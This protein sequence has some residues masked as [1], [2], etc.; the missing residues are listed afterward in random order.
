M[1]K[2]IFTPRLAEII[3]GTHLRN[4]VLPVWLVES[5]IEI[6][7]MFNPDINEANLI[8]VSTNLDYLSEIIWGQDVEVATGVKSL[9]NSSFVL[10]HN[11]YQNGR[12]CARGQVTFI[13]YDYAAGV[14]KSIPQK[15]RLK[16]EEHLTEE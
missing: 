8:I 7:K 14:P 12:L 1:L 15:I 9:G 4:D 5:S 3:G 10:L 11:V 6:Q 2:K 13:H 16:L